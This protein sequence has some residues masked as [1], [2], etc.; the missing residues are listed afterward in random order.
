VA[1]YIV[2]GGWILTLGPLFGLATNVIAQIACAH[3]TRRTNLSIVTGGIGG[4]VVTGL[5]AS[6]ASDQ[7][8]YGRLADLATAL[9]TYL[10]LAFGYWAFL[11]MNSTSLRIRMI[12]E[13][14][15]AGTGI[16]HS[17]L[18]TRYSAEEFLQRRLERLKAS[19]KQLS[20]VN[21]RW[22]LTSR[23]FLVMGWALGAAR[24]ILYPYPSEE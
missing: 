17:E 24:A 5:C 13:L 11:T 18:M 9:L 4:L 7:P 15:N 1:R 12:R 8:L 22:R 23:T 6:T 2:S 16:S 3:L 14:L 19:S 10:A 21:G 20:C